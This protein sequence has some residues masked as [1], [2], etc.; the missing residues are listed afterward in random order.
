MSRVTLFSLLLA[1]LLGT[2]IQLVTLQQRDACTAYLTGQ[3]A[4][5]KSEWVISGTREI[6]VPCNDWFSRQ[7]LQIQLLAVLNAV[8]AVVFALSALSDFQS[9]RAVRRRRRDTPSLPPVLFTAQRP[10]LRPG[11]MGQKIPPIPLSLESLPSFKQHKAAPAAK[12]ASVDSQHDGTSKGRDVVA[13]AL[14]RNRP[15]GRRLPR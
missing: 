14:R 6:L 9:W 5:Q 7:P 3:Q 15:N 2:G 13:R 11:I 10:R 4:A 12:P 8:L 1:L